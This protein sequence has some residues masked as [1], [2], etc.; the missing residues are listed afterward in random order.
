MVTSEEWELS[1]TEY[2]RI[3]TEIIE[4]CTTQIT[5]IRKKKAP[6]RVEEAENL[7]REFQVF[8]KEKSTMS[9]VKSECHNLYDHLLILASQSR[10][11][12][13]IPN[14]LDFG[15]LEALW[16]ELENESA[17]HE[18]LIKAELERLRRLAAICDEIDVQIGL[19][20]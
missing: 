10:G 5:I 9:I 12:F 14:E 2:R 6:Q 3:Y 18:A 13:S 7:L 19:K 1:I 11:A 16:S 20:I 15:R 4:W 8:L 17:N